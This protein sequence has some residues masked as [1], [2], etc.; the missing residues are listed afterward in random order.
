MIDY[1]IHENGWTIILDSDL[2]KANQEDINHISRLLNK[3]TLVVSKKQNLSVEEHLRITKMF[4]NPVFLDPTLHHDSQS[5]VVP[6]TDGLLL[7][8]GGKRNEYGIPGIAESIGEVIW[9]SDPHWP[10]LECM[11][12]CLSAICG[13][14]NSMTSWCN[15]QLAYIDL[16]QETKDILNTLT[17][18]LLTG[19][20]FNKD[21]SFKDESGLM[22]PPSSGVNRSG[23]KPIQF[24]KTGDKGLYFP[25]NQIHSFEEMSEKNSRTLIKKISEHITQE[26]YCYHHS[27]DDGDIIFTDQRFGLHM[28]HRCEHTDT[29][30]LYRSVFDYQDQDYELSY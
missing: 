30:S 21:L 27:W 2:K 9:H 13:T 5:I 15:T 19:I 11:I 24:N 18:V 3:H 14:S 29:R 23:I 1:H 17:L 8:V 22:R 7:R 25:F 26:K 16:D 4:K 10:N 6:N 12:I 28:R 20:D